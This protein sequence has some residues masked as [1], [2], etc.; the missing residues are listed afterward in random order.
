LQSVSYQ[1]IECVAD[2]GPIIYL[3]KVEALDVLAGAGY[4]AFLPPGVVAETVRPDVAYRYPDAAAIR[5]ALRSG[6]L[7]N[8]RLTGP[9]QTLADRFATEIPALGRGERETLAVATRRAWP[10]LLYERRASALART[11]GIDTAGLVELLFQGTPDPALLERRVRAFAEL[12][13]MRP[14]DRESLLRRIPR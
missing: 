2:S 10:A 11:L 4:V 1:L 13:Y 3:A 8:L 14:E 6:I 7:R 5:E 9:E 12:V